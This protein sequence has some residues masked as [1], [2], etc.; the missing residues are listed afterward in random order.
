MNRMLSGLSML[1]DTSYGN[2]V[3]KGP[4]VTQGVPAAISFRNKIP[5]AGLL[6]V[7]LFVTIFLGL[8]QTSLWDRDEPRNSQCAAEMLEAGD[9]VVPT[10]NGNLRTHKPV[11]LYWVQMFWY[12]IFGINAFAARFGGALGASAT[13]FCIYFFV[14]RRVNPNA[15]LFCGGVLAT[16]LMFVVA[17]RAATPDALLI[18]FA[19]LAVLFCVE[20]IS[21]ND[22]RFLVAG[23]I[24]MGLSVLAKGPV[25]MVFPCA[26]IVCWLLAESFSQHL[27]RITPIDSMNSSAL[28]EPRPMLQRILKQRLT[29]QVNAYISA[30]IEIIHPRVWF[31]ILFRPAWLFAVSVALC[32]AVPWYICVGVRTDGEWLRGFFLEHNLGRATGSMEGHSGGVWFYPAASLL[33]LFPWS[34]LL[35]P[36]LIWWKRHL[37]NRSERGNLVR[38][39][40]VWLLLYMVVFSLAKTKLPS[41]ITPAYPGACLIIGCFLYDLREGKFALP[42]WLW[43]LAGGVFVLTMIATASAISFA[44]A[45]FESTQLGLCS[46]VGLVFL[47]A[48]FCSFRIANTRFLQRQFAPV[49]LASCTVFLGLL[50]GVA[51]PLISRQ[52]LE[53]TLFAGALRE[54]TETHDLRWTAIGTIEP[55]WVF[56]MKSPITEYPSVDQDNDLRQ[57]TSSLQNH[58]DRL[59]IS[60]ELARSLDE[61]FPGEF[62]V[63]YRF[64]RFLSNDEMC[65]LKR[66]DLRTASR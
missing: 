51:A 7:V 15:G 5:T 48:A 28:P 50:F 38:L 12:S 45:R 40:T 53:L 35:L 57:A 2:A 9:W 10:F 16:S 21:Q 41:Y 30:F 36:I 23:S 1:R 60:D 49:Y 25:G 56:Y 43:R 46:V 34:L 42:T 65:I 29:S 44:G 18:C 27:G 33:G 17:A 11:L 4:E 47:V 39:G 52:R 13:V 3:A 59:L 58:N 8:G 37:M 54:A 6:A 32:I 19:S 64:R 14:A 55:S 22:R 62:D 20:F 61:T 31:N 24:C 66:S 26:I 63:E